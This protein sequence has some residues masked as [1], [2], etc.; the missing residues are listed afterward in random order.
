MPRFAARLTNVAAQPARDVTASLAL[1]EGVRLV[2]GTATQRPPPVA[3]SA[4]I[5]WRVRSRQAHR[6]ATPG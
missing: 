4:R 2:E 5:T 3:D 6:R 1:P